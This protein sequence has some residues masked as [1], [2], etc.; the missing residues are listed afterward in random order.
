MSEYGQVVAQGGQ[1]AG[2]GGGGPTDLGGAIGAGFTNA[3]NQASATLGIS[4]SLLLVI[5]VAAL[6][7]VAWFVFAR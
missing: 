7:F 2:S 1:A 3:L 4:P 6:L 5:V